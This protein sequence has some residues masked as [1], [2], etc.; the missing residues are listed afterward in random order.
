MS[1]LQFRVWPSCRVYHRFAPLHNA[2]TG[3]WRR[4]GY[5]KQNTWCHWITSPKQTCAALPPNKAGVEK[6]CLTMEMYS[7]LSCNSL[8][9]TSKPSH[10]AKRTIVL[11]PNE[12]W[13]TKVEC[14]RR[15]RLHFSKCRW[16][17]SPSISLQ[18]YICYAWN[19]NHKHDTDRQHI[20]SF[21]AGE[22]TATRSVLV[23]SFSCLAR[24]LFINF[25]FRLNIVYC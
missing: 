14:F 19:N 15:A 13:T 16:R 23:T 25:D 10:A 5:G 8:R 4:S 3:A 11:R 20:V 24:H 18:T 22:E 6:T 7:P 9:E 12:L 17:F 2:R 21:F 1:L